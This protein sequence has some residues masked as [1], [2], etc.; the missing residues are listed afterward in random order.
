MLSEVVGGLAVWLVG[1][2]GFVI[3]LQIRS[4]YILLKLSYALNF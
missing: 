3:S 1:F 2:E 4:S